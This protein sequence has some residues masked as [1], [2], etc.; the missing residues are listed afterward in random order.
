MPDILNKIDESPAFNNKGVTCFKSVLNYVDSGAFFHAPVWWLYVLLGVFSALAPFYLLFDFFIP[1]FKHMNAWPIIVS[2]VAWVVMLA[3]GLVKFLLWW[4][5]KDQLA[6]LA[7]VGDDFPVTPI[8][9]HFNR[10]LGEWL[11]F[12][13][14]VEF[15]LVSLI[16]FL[17]AGG[18]ARRLLPVSGLGMIFALPVAGF[19]I[20]FASRFVSEIIRALAAIAVNTKKTADKA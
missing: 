19:V 17:L 1:M 11:G 10:T 20:I 16:V 5:R 9:A 3:C 12:T 14:G 2:I 4:N 6:A 7:P 13:V 8:F 15:F 18:D